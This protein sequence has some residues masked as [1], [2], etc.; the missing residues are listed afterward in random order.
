MKKVLILMIAA[1]FF[2]QYS[3]M[4]GGN[5]KF[6]VTGNYKNADKLFSASANGK[7]SGK[8]F[9]VEVYY[10]KDQNPLAIDSALISG[11]ANSFR[12]TGKVKKEGVYEL[13]FGDNLLAIPLVNDV[14]KVTINVDLA[15]KDD[16]YTVENS[17]ATKILQNLIR[18]LGKKNYQ[19]GQDFAEI[20]SLKKINAPDSV[21][22]AAITQ[23]NNDVE[24]L[25]NFFKHFFQTSANGTVTG[26]AL[27]WASR[28][29]SQQEFESALYASFKKFPSNDLL[30][31]MKKNYDL[32]KALAQQQ[33]QQSA[34]ASWVGQQAPD[35]NLPDANGKIIPISSFKG[36]YL[37]VDFWAS[38]CGP[39][40]AENPNVVK[41]YNEFRNK[42]FAVL[43]VSLDKDKDA[44]QQAIKEDGLAW[45]H[46]SDLKYW[47]SK[48]V[49]VY[50]FEGI[51]F[52]ILIDPQGKIIGQE[53]RGSA[54]ENKLKEALQ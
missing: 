26:L 35:L 51:P 37:L 47:S 34:S 18:D 7:I 24:S 38:W 29:F 4:Q 25:N 6:V 41:A 36:K 3:C 45:T 10:G 11:N 50:K 54:L 40:R 2:I 43:G 33:A 53:L 8:V 48:A 23:K 9:L 31:D 15:S 46:V 28:S 32:Q 30:M 12:L 27:N 17:D 5:G 20:D 13:V 21:V 39:C 1:A 42:N 14:S 44:W 16:F 22:L 19:V 52:N 49:D